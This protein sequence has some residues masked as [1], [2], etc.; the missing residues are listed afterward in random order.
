MLTNI[1]F[2]KPPIRFGKFYFRIGQY[3]EFFKGKNCRINVFYPSPDG[4]TL[5]EKLPATRMAAKFFSSLIQIPRLMANAWKSELVFVFPSPTMSIYLAL[6]KLF[7]KQVVIEHILSYVSHHDVFAWYPVWL[8]RWVYQSA[9]FILTHT[10]TMKS[11]LTARLTLNPD[12]VLVS[13]CS[14]DLTNFVPKYDAQAAELKRKFEISGKKVVLYHGLHHD[15]HGAEL[16]MEAASL[17]RQKREDIVFV[18]LPGFSET[19]KRDGN[20]LHLTEKDHYSWETLPIYLQMADL[21]ASGFRVVE[22]GERTFGSTL[23]QALAMGRPVLTS[24]GR[25][26]NKFLTD[27]E[28]VFYVKPDSASDLADKIDACFNQPDEMRRVAR[29]ARLTAEKFFSISHL[30]QML[31]RVCESVEAA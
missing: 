7:G 30:E 24:P 17:L 12:R 29:N 1:L 10:E 3:V 5:L 23:I 15:W 11:E 9:D 18:L 6:V 4:S 26:K 13:Y 28:N 20:L 14:V 31:N 27:G 2:I 8:D 25:E 21:W 19:W 22:R 16:L